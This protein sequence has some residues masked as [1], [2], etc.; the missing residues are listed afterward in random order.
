LR[1]TT[2]SGHDSGHAWDGPGCELFFADTEDPFLVRQLVF[3]F[4]G[5]LSDSRVRVPA[6]LSLSPNR[7]DSWN[8]TWRVVT[9][10][11]EGRAVAEVEIPLNEIVGADAGPGRVFRFDAQRRIPGHQELLVEWAPIPLARNFS[12]AHLGFAVLADASS[13]WQRYVSKDPASLDL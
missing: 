4:E 2:A 11:E 3:N 10:S 9:Y 8:P 13:E 7:D 5:H 6:D 12:P 1:S